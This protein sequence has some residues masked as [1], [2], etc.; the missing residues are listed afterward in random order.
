MGFDCF[1]VISPYG[2]MLGTCTF[3][4]AGGYKLGHRIGGGVC[5]CLGGIVS[6]L[7]DGCNFVQSAATIDETPG[8]RRLGRAYP[9]RAKRNFQ[10]QFGAISATS[11]GVG[12]F[13]AVEG[14]HTVL[15]RR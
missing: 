9:H 7:L 12:Q 14:I 6:D 3:V 1:C 15:H 11:K 8:F 2:R 13:V 5:F 10:T 4:A